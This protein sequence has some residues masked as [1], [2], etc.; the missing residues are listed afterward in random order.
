[1]KYPFAE[2]QPLPDEVASGVSLRL[3]HRQGV[4]FNE[5]KGVYSQPDS[6]NYRA[7]Q[8]AVF[9][10]NTYNV[11]SGGDP[12]VIPDLTFEKFQVPLTQPPYTHTHTHPHTHTT[13]TPTQAHT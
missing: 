1:V 6:M 7:I 3:C 10:T 4:V 5:M 8:S 13:H 9:P 11:D 2:G 12:V